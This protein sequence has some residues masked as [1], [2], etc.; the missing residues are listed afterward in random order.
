MNG[1]DDRD[2]RGGSAAAG[3][4]ADVERV[5]G[6]AATKLARDL[7]EARDRREHSLTDAQIDDVVMCHVDAMVNDAVPKILAVVD[8]V[9]DRQ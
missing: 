3:P 9:T 7:R 8:R 5:I 2:P 1:A 6:G 4:L